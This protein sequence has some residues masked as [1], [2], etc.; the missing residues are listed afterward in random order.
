MTPGVG[1]IGLIP[2]G[3]SWLA[4]GVEGITLSNV[5]HTLIM[6]P[7]GRVAHVA[8]PRVSIELA[9]N[10]PTAIW[11][12]FT[13]TPAQAEGIVDWVMARVGAPYNWASFVLIGYRHVAGRLPHPRVVQWVDRGRAY[14]CAQF[15]DAALAEGAGVKAFDDGRPYGLVGPGD[16][17]KLFIA[18]EWWPTDFIPLP[19]LPGAR[20]TAEYIWPRAFTVARAAATRK[21]MLRRHGRAS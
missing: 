1:Q 7:G 14:Q 11:S 6:L 12:Q 21:I 18:H 15:A 13:L 9:S 17:E 2:Y 16:F 5:H 8:H 10:F 20:G 4:R 3:G 19:R